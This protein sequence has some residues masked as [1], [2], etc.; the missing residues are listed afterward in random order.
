MERCLLFAQVCFYLSLG[1][2]GALPRDLWRVNWKPLCW[3]KLRFT[4]W[5]Q[6]RFAI[7]VEGVHWLSFL[8]PRLVWAIIT[9]VG[10]VSIFPLS[11][12]HLQQLKSKTSAPKS[13]AACSPSDK[14][15]QH[16]FMLNGVGGGW[17]TSMPWR[18]GAPTVSW[19]IRRHHWASS[20]HH[21]AADTVQV[22]HKSSGHE[23]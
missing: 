11:N 10:S 19:A 21:W 7:Q 20:A 9:W 3:R 12:L 6:K 2:T 5:N 8:P 22:S 1:L 23:L 13:G 17:M 16:L 18:L 4:K 14:C 15:S